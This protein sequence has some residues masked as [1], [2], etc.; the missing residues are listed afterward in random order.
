MKHLHSFLLMLLK[1]KRL[2][3]G[4]PGESL[5]G[6]ADRSFLFEVIVLNC[7]VNGKV[8]IVARYYVQEDSS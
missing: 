3:I 5:A 2:Y 1:V 6:F 8:N 4:L 7:C